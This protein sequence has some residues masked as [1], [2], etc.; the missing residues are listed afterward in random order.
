MYA[1]VLAESPKT[2]QKESTHNSISS[3]P[4]AI[5]IRAV[6][7]FEIAMVVARLILGF[8]EGGVA[9]LFRIVGRRLEVEQHTAT[10]QRS[11]SVTQ[12]L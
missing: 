11:Y 6:R 9:M 12:M 10:D 2:I 5:K 1:P 7:S 3:V 4:S 8:L